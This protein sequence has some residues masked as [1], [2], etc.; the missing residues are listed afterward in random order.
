MPVKPASSPVRLIF[1]GTPATRVPGGTSKPS[2][3]RHAAATIEPA[4]V[5]AQHGARPHGRLGPDRDPADDDRLGMD[6]RG[7]VDLGL[8]LAQRV[9]RHYPGPPKA[10][11]RLGQDIAQLPAAIS[12]STPNR[13]W[14]Q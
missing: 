14:S 3:T 7:L 8:V 1:A 10:G 4:L 6:E 12:P 11:I 2:G 5:A 9:Y 13:C